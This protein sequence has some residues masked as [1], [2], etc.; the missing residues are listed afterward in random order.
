MPFTDYPPTV[1]FPNTHKGQLDW[2]KWDA[3]A[4]TKPYFCSEYEWD[5]KLCARRNPTGD[6]RRNICY[7]CVA[8]FLYDFKRAVEQNAHDN[9]VKI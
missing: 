9:R 5:D 6:R 8:G 1:V 3:S 7:R 4:D 2:E